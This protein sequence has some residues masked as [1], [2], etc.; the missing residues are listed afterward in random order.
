ML[1]KNKFGL[2][3]VLINIILTLFMLTNDNIDLSYYIVTIISNVVAIIFSI[4]IL[5]HDKKKILDIIFLI[6]NI[7][8]LILVIIY[9]LLQYKII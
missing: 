2:Y 3:V 7:L 8:I 6:C 1:E 4:Y 9:T 5:K